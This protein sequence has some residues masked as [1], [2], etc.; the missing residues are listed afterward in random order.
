MSASKLLSITIAAPIIK[1]GLALIG[2]ISKYATINH[3]EFM[4]I[5][6]K[7]D[8]IDIKVSNIANECIKLLFLNDKIISKILKL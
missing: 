6:Q 7:G 5:E 2:D 8:K 4:E 1:K 3:K